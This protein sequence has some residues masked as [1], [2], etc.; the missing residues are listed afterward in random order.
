MNG[1]TC[2]FIELRSE[3]LFMLKFRIRYLKYY[4]SIFEAF[5]HEVKTA[6]LADL[7]EQVGLL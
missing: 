7:T 6:E 5:W 2:Y 4:A 3:L 1:S